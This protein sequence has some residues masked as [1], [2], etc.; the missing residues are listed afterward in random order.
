MDNPPSD[1]E[2]I[3]CDPRPAFVL[4]RDFADGDEVRPHAHG[5]AQLLHA[6][7]GVILAR[8]PGRAWAVPPGR[9]LWIPPGVE[10]SFSMRGRV[11]VRTLYVRPGASGDEP[12][13]PVVMRVSPLVRELVLRALETDAAVPA[14]VMPLLIHELKSMARENLGLP[15]P[16]SGRMRAFADLVSAD[17]ADRRPLEEL[18]HSLGLT[19][20]TLARRFQ[21]ETGMTPDGWRRQMRLLEAVALL[22]SGRSVTD[23][24]FDLGYRSVS[25]FSHAFR[26]SFGMTPGEARR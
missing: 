21:V 14:L 7:A 8:T 2:R 4:A 23:V 12:V 11:L 17:P 26:Q 22:R 15:L 3:A 19:A 13:E 1:L 25:S 16:V 18:A 24:A 9:A 10:H 6:V 5:A 20:R